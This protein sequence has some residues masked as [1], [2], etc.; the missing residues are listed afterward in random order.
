MICF[1]F[2]DGR[3]YR[4]VAGKQPLAS[5][6]L[7][8]KPGLSFQRML[9][10]ETCRHKALG[11]VL[12][13]LPEIK[14]CPEVTPT[15]ASKI[16]FTEE[17]SNKVQSYSI[18]IAN[19]SE[20]NWFRTKILCKFKITIQRRESKFNLRGLSTSGNEGLCSL[21][22]LLPKASDAFPSLSPQ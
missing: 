2:L 15:P 13:F 11:N 1:D 6:L 12:P 16:N 22:S 10:A 5:S 14:L 20:L 8:P 18:S 19:E 9:L 21:H 3:T 4:R 7:C 17:L